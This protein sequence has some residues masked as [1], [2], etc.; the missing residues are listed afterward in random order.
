MAPMAKVMAGGGGG[1][2]EDLHSSVQEEK[3]RQREARALLCYE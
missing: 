3:T 2:W 1:R